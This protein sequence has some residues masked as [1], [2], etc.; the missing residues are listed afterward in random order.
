MTS[1]VNDCFSLDERPNTQQKNEIPLFV[2]SNVHKHDKLTI[3]DK[4]KQSTI[5]SNVTALKPQYALI[6]PSIDYQPQKQQNWSIKIKACRNFSSSKNT[7]AVGLC[8][9]DQ[10][11][12]QNF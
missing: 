11:M 2:F 8:S 4:E 1:K 12:G 3:L 5:K 9:L 6:C 7:I 10:V